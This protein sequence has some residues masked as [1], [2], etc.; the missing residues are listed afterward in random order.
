MKSSLADKLIAGK[1]KVTSI[2]TVTY[3]TLWQTA[4]KSSRWF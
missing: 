4:F 2:L 1:I 3:P